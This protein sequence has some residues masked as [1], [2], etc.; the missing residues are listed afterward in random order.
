[1][2]VTYSEC[3]FVA[4]G[5][6]HAMS[7]RHIVVCCLSDSSILF[8]RR[9]DFRKKKVIEHEMFF[10]VQ[11]LSETFLISRRIQRNI[12]INVHM[13]LCKVPVMLVGF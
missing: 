9:H 3:V 5:I 7:M 2:S 8:Q 12:I 1:M 10:F 6:H 11:L 4:L 13:C